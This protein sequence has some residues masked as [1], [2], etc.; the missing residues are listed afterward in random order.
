M[1]AVPD[2]STKL[3][4]TDVRR[5]FR[6]IGEIRQHGADPQQW[7]PHLLRGLIDLLDTDLVISSEVH[8]RTIAKSDALQVTDIGWGLERNGEPWRIHSE[9]EENPETYLV[10]AGKSAATADDDDAAI[11]DIVPIK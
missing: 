5:A 9:R 3:R 10:V 2:A 1:P 11:R 8:F 4:L 6:L 7:R